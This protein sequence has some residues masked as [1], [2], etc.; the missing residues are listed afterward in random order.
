MTDDD[1]VVRLLEE[2]RATHHE[3]LELYKQGLKN[4][5]DSV[6]LQRDM[7]AAAQKRL[8][9]VPVLI[10]VV[11]FLI[12]IVLGLMARVLFIRYR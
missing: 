10:G 5:M 8:R 3:H 6:A 4:Q 1:R 9:F 7:A 2:I 12:A 11:F